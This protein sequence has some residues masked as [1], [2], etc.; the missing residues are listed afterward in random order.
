MNQEH[1]HTCKAILIKCIDFRLEKEM[2]HWLDENNLTGDCDIVSLAG[3][4]QELSNKKEIQDLF[5]KQIQI[6]HNLHQASQVILVHH[7]D[8]GAYK[9]IYHFKN[10]TE[11]RIVQIKDMNRA[12]KIIKENFPDMVI[13]KIWAQLND[14]QGNFI[15]F[16]T[17]D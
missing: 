7:S 1:K 13:K 6:A 17:I 11:E 16:E 9:N 3:A 2:R 12:E 15:T 4:T 14:I 5:L 8:C 10:E